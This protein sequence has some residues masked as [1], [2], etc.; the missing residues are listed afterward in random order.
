[1]I[2]NIE[3]LLPKRFSGWREYSTYEILPFISKKEQHV[4]IDEKMGDAT[5]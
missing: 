1:L 4:I 2:I 5:L 3:L